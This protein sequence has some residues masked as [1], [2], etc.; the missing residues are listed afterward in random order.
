MNLLQWRDILSDMLY[1]YWSEGKPKEG[2]AKGRKAIYRG[3]QYHEFRIGEISGS[4]NVIDYT[5]EDFTKRGELYNFIFDAVIKLSKS[6]FRKALTPNGIYGG[7]G[8]TRKAE[9]SAEHLNFI[10]ELI[11][12]GK[13]KAVIDRRYPLEQTAEAHRYV[14]KGHKKGNIV[15]TAEPNNKT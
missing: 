7:A 10:K 4:D 8:A 2:L 5:K 3:I 6:N 13:I 1:G 9:L 12:A 15:I 14:E 11:E